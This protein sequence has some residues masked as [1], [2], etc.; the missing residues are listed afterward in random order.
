MDSLDTLFS[1]LQLGPIT[2]LKRN[3]T[4]VGGTER[5]CPDAPAKRMRSTNIQFGQA[6]ESSWPQT[7]L[8]FHPPY[9]KA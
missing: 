7:K 9:G 6:S 2:P 5:A 8:V 4:S 3:D 1:Q